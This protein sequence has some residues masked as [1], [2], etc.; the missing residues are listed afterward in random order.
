MIIQIYAELHGPIRR[1]KFDLYLNQSYLT[2]N[3]VR[4]QKHNDTECVIFY[5]S[6]D[7][8][9]NENN[10]VLEIHQTDKT[11]LDN[12][13]GE[14]YID[15]KQIVV[16]GNVLNDIFLQKFSTFKHS[17]SAQWVSDMKQQGYDIQPVYTPGTQLR[18]NGKFSVEFPKKIW[19]KLVKAMQRC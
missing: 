13:N 16:D 1:P 18:L 10:N 6:T 19:T 7:I 2:P 8:V 5:Y 11:D 17:M 15:I 3:N 9:L 14:H 12:L 4:A